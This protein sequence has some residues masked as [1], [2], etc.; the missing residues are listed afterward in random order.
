MYSDSDE[1][2]IK[3]SQTFIP[4]IIMADLNSRN[5]SRSV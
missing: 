3:K 5:N 1:F 2:S 4:E